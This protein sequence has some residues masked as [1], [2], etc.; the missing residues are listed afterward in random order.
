[1]SKHDKQT[2]EEK[3]PAKA[4]LDWSTP[5]AAPPTAEITPEETAPAAPQAE[6][7]EPE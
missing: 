6:K 2:P 4:D 7:K 3:A 1:M 5:R